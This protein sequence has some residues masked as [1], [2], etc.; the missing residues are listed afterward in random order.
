MLVDMSPKG[1][2]GNIAEETLDKAGI[3]VNKNAIPFDT[4]KANVTSGIRVGTP[5]VTTRGMGP[6]HMDIIGDLMHRALESVGDDAK[7]KSVACEVAEFCS[8]FALHD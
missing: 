2:T 7:L 4:L 8:G 5:A 1:L 3:T 6:E